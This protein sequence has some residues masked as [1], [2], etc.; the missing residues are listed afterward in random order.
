MTPRFVTVLTL[1]A[2]CLMACLWYGCTDNTVTTV[3]PEDEYLPA[4]ETSSFLPLTKGFTTVY[5]VTYATGGSQT[6][7]LEIGR[8]VQNGPLTAYE[9]FSD[10]G[11]TL[12][13]GYVIVTTGA[14]FFYDGVNADPEKILAFPLFAGNTWER[15][16]DSY[17]ND[18]FTDIIT[19]IVDDGTD[20]TNLDGGLAKTLPTTGG[21]IMTV[22]GEEQLQLSSGLFLS[23][24]IKIYNDG[25]TPGK[26][27]Y[28]WYTEGVGLVKY[29]IGTT[30]GSFPRGDVVGE[31][32]DFGS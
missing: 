11:L 29:I 12:D 18:G 13:T 17:A 30:D 6:I 10:D 32:I 31:L 28:Y 22:V 5:N 25:T 16:S 1:A 24:T 7:T 14:A 3:I 15:F 21:N 2:L 19:G 8:Q 4:T 20:P 26:K 9:W 23:N 27:N